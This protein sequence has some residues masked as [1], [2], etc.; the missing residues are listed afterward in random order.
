M[1]CY[2]HIYNLKRY[3]IR[4]EREQIPMN[5]TLELFSKLAGMVHLVHGSRIIHRDIK[6]EN[7]L[8]MN[9][10]LLLLF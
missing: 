6:P 10:S 1:N 5:V 8:V 3:L 2:I 9:V 4:Y 7:I